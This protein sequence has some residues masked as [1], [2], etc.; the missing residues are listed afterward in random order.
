MS[1]Q[2]HFQNNASLVQLSID[3]VRDQLSF[4]LL[5]L[6]I[7]FLNTLASL[8]SLK[9]LLSPSSIL[10]QSRTFFFFK[11]FFINELFASGRLVS[12]YS[13]HVYNALYGKSEL[14]NTIHCFYLIMPGHFS[15]RNQYTLT[16]A[17]SLDRVRSLRVIERKKLAEQPKF[18]ATA[19]GNILKIALVLTINTILSIVSVFDRFDSD[20]VIMCLG[21]WCVGQHGTLVLVAP[22]GLAAWLTMCVYSCMLFMAFCKWKKTAAGQSG[23]ENSKNNLFYV[24]LIYQYLRRRNL[25]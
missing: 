3:T 1:S 15:M 12:L 22:V 25:L 14:I 2:D 8:L 6:L 4:S 20:F 24:T 23:V 11:L 7:G 17:I 10:Y 13:W 21:T 19:P 9:V 18:N 5:S 16:L